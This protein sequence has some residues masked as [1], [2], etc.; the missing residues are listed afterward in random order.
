MDMARTALNVIGNALAVLVVSRWEGVYDQ[1][2]GERYW[3]ALQEGKAEELL[4]GNKSAA[5]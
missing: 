1:K 5:H 3:A 4:E 2:K